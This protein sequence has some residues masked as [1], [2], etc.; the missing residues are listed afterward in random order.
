MYG[1]QEYSCSRNVLSHVWPHLLLSTGKSILAQSSFTSSDDILDFPSLGLSAIMCYTRRIESTQLTIHTS[2][3]DLTEDPADTVDSGRATPTRTRRSSIVGWA[4]GDHHHHPFQHV[5]VPSSSSPVLT[6]IGPHV[7][8][9]A[10]PSS[11]GPL[12]WKDAERVILGIL[13]FPAR[14]D[15]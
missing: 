1:R 4:S 11:N 6:G 14:D 12:A 7:S 5:H 13:S 10:P 2:V 9:G 15:C 3:A 8:S